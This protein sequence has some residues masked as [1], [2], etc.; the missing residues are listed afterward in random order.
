MSDDAIQR[1]D[2]VSGVDTFRI[3]SGYTKKVATFGQFARSC[4]LSAG[5]VHPIPS[6]THPAPQHAFFRGR[7]VNLFQVTGYRL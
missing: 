4:D 3:A 1:F 5:T 6:R 2:C 7:A